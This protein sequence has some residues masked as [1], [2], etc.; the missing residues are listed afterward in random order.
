[1]PARAPLTRLVM[2]LLAL[3]LFAS[4]AWSQEAEEDP[5]YLVEDFNVGMPDFEVPH[6]RDT[7]Q[8]AVEFFLD[9]ADREAFAD[10][11]Q[12]LNLSHIPPEQQ[13]RRGPDL[14]RKLVYLLESQSLIDWNRL[15]D[16]PDAQVT[17]DP[18]AANQSVSQPF[19]R[20]TIQLGTISDRGRP[21]PINLQRHRLPGGEMLWAFSPYTVGNVDRLYEV[22]G[23]GVLE[24]WVREN[25][26]K[27]DY[28]TIALWEWVVLAVLIG[29]AL[30]LYLLTHRL[31]GLLPRVFDRDWAHAIIA[32][33]QRPVSWLTS[34]VV[35][36]VAVKSLL[37]LDGVLTAHIDVFL[38]AV[39]F[40][41]ATWAVSRVAGTVATTLATR[42]PAADPDG[43]QL[44]R[45]YQTNIAVMRRV[46]LFVAAVVGVGLLLSYL[47][48]FDSIGMSLLASTGA[49]AVILGL[50]ARPV[51]S[52]LV[53]SV[54]IALT[55]P[56][57]I[58]DVVEIGGHWGRVEDIRFMYSVVRTW[59]QQRVIVPHSHLLT[60]PFENWSKKDMTTSRVVELPVDLGTDLEALRNY[61]KELMTDDPRWLDSDREMNVVEVS[62]EAIKVWVWVT[63]RNA[64]ESWY[65]AAD[66]R[67]DLIGWLQRQEGL[68]LPHER[69]I[70]E[71]EGDR[72]AGTTEEEQDP[73]A[74]EAQSAPESKSEPSEART[75]SA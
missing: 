49:F 36:L 13:A 72:A 71:R 74:E 37:P 27:S 18:A 45:T 75:A 61:C 60:E 66:V 63:G 42:G 34:A 20:R 12:I 54:Q 41:L 55:K 29:C 17:P 2:T 50:A 19:S 5:V 26:D 51:L 35:L 23:P 38:V 73:A 28:G 30:L 59:T 53:E 4:A 10:A 43:E 9:A 25:L 65:L 47:D 33:C 52:G 22:H 40:L 31:M 14:A 62:T 6:V 64:T 24:R 70:V 57:E 39:I 16:V 58:G 21:V 32:C 46:V 11:A 3:V 69:H 68:Y 1:M 15:P 56:I 8:S 7:P 67:E 44:A 48:V